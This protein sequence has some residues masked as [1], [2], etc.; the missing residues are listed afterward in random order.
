MKRA[1]E[2]DTVI[3]LYSDAQ[4]LSTHPTRMFEERK[5][6]KKKEKRKR[7]ERRKEKR[8]RRGKE[9]EEREGRE[10]VLDENV[11]DEIECRKKY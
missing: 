5:N 2:S 8:N 10:N 6:I 4:I 1:T 9:R 7:R 3:P 11:Q